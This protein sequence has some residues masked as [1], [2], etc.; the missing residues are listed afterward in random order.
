M[1][2]TPS[3]DLVTQIVDRTVTLQKRLLGEYMADAMSNLK[4]ETE[5]LI[6]AEFGGEKGY[7]SKAM[8]EKLAA[9]DVNVMADLQAGRSIRDVAKKWHLSK[10]Q[11]Q[12]LKEGIRSGKVRSLNPSEMAK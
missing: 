11:V 7:L 2:L 10:S 6:R 3:D 4:R 12:R 1:A 9:R 8:Q 5:A